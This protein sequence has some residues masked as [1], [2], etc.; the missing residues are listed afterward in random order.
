MNLDERDPAVALANP[1]G[2]QVFGMDGHS[3]TTATLADGQTW[4]VLREL[5][6]MLGLENVS[7]VKKR[8]RPDQMATMR[9]TDG[10]GNPNSIMVSESGMWKLVMTSRT[11]LGRRVEDLVTTEVLPS[12]RK[13][14][15]Y[16][17][18]QVIA[19]NNHAL[20]V[21]DSHADAAIY[22][23][24]RAH[25]QAENCRTC[26]PDF[27]LYAIERLRDARQAQ[28]PINEM[29]NRPAIP[30]T[31]A[32]LDQIRSET[33]R[34]VLGLPPFKVSLKLTAQAY[35]DGAVDQS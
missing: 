34:K 1:E 19:A 8:L 2:L 24:S 6:D 25:R 23:M 15:Y 3:L 35:A 16:A 26:R 5:C 30:V 20:D 32:T 14:G 7:H 21:Y 13:R 4:F 31:T 22:E 28:A 18:D 17:T 12:I 11:A 33:V 29:N 10:R 9:R 27:A